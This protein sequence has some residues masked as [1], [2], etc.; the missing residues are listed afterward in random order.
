MK[1]LKVGLLGRALAS[2]MMDVDISSYD[3]ALDVNDL[4]RVWSEV[5][6]DMNAYLPANSRWR[7]FTPTSE[8][9]YMNAMIE[10]ADDLV[11]REESDLFELVD[12]EE[13]TDEEIVDS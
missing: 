1:F 6:R 5:I 8:E 9:E 3:M 10:I 7:T 2:T 4:E 13:F 12:L 11:Y